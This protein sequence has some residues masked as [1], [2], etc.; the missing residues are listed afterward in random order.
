MPL[1]GQGQRWKVAQSEGTQSWVCNYLSCDDG[2]N[3]RY[4]SSLLLDGRPLLQL[5]RQDGLH[6]GGS[7]EYLSGRVVRVHKDFSK[8]CIDDVRLQGRNLPLP[9]GVNGTK[10]GQVTTFRNVKKKC[11]PEGVCLNVSCSFP[12]SCVDNWQL[13]HCGIEEL[14]RGR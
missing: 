2:D 4:N 7:P 8:G 1:Q 13:Y 3:D 5:S 11:I 12:L 6:L 9:P 10:W 14:L